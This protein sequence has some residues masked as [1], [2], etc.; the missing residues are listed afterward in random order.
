MHLLDD[1]HIDLHHD[2]NLV[3]SL[4]GI[5]KDAEV[6]GLYGVFQ[7]VGYDLVLCLLEF[8]GSQEIVWSCYN[9]DDPPIYGYDF[10]AR[11]NYDVQPLRA[12]KRS[13]KGS[14]I[15]VHIPGYEVRLLQI[16][17]F[18]LS[19]AAILIASSS[20]VPLVLVVVLILVSLIRWF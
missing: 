8:G 1:I 7:L 4:T 15:F 11:Q 3:L 20:A 2:G 14:G 19:Q 18:E 13:K 5:S 10:T 9:G 17:Q 6:L 12:N 16:S